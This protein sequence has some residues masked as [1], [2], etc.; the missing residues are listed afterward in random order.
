MNRAV[1]KGPTLPMGRWVKRNIIICRDSESR[2]KWRCE[3]MV[4]NVKIMST[5]KANRDAHV[6]CH[7]GVSKL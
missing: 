7:A 3:G 1:P 5:K 2:M 4:D 6:M